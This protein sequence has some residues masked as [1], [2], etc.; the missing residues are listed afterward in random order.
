MPICSGQEPLQQN[1]RAAKVIATAEPDCPASAKTRRY[2]G[3]PGRFQ[4][5]WSAPHHLTHAL[6]PLGKRPPNAA[7][8]SHLEDDEP[9]SLPEPLSYSVSPPP[10]DHASRRPPSA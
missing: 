7:S 9:C 6:E 4:K 5:L 2:A 10:T 3:D 1:W 8:A